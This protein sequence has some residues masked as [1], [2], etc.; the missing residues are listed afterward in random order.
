MKFTG[1]ILAGN[2][3]ISLGGEIISLTSFLFQPHLKSKLNNFK[4]SVENKF[5]QK[6]VFFKSSEDAVTLLSRNYTDLLIVATKEKLR[7]SLDKKSSVNEFE[8]TSIVRE[9]NSYKLDARIVIRTDNHFQKQAY[10]I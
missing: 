1:I 5:G 4:C 9:E 8:I 6:G 2:N 10:F 7:G 3:I